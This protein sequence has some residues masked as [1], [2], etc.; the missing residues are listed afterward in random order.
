MIKLLLN[1]FKRESAESI[2][3]NKNNEIINFNDSDDFLLKNI[4]KDSCAY[5]IDFPSDYLICFISQ[6]NKEEFLILSEAVRI[7][8]E[9]DN[10]T[11][12]IFLDIDMDSEDLIFE[13]TASLK[14][15]PRNEESFY[16]ESFDYK[17][18]CYLAKHGFAKKEVKESPITNE[19]I[20]KMMNKNEII[21][22]LNKREIPFKKSSTKIELLKI[23]LSNTEISS[24]VRP[25]K[26]IR[27]SINRV[28]FY[29]Q[30]YKDIM[31]NSENL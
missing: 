15:E 22:A 26:I 4:E 12:F 20:L 25:G 11:S 10:I 17:K 5:E 7:F 24:L 8:K 19:L 27:F 28:D 3:R 21:Q 2:N 9:I 14:S 18:L 29:N 30:I 23:L 6:H 16:K 13:E 31:R 1:L